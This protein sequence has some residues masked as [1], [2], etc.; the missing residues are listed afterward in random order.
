MNHFMLPEDSSSGDA[1]AGSIRRSGLATRYGSHAMESLINELLKLGARRSRLEIKLFGGGRILA[2]ITDV[3]ARNIEFVHEYLKTRRLSRR[4]P[5]TS[6]DISRASVVYFPDDRQGE[7]AQAASARS[8]RRIAERERKYLDRHR[9]RR[10]PA[11]ATS[12]CSI[13]RAEQT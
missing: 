8:D 11:A 7:S 1:T 12:S 4:S 3:G 13:E 2:S 10:K 9:H 5:R 6:A